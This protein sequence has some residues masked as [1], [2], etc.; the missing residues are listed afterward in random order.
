M[1]AHSPHIARKNRCLKHQMY[2]FHQGDATGWTPGCVLECELEAVVSTISNLTIPVPTQS[3]RALTTCRQ[4]PEI[5]PR[6]NLRRY[7]KLQCLPMNNLGHGHLNLPMTTSFHFYPNLK[8]FRRYLNRKISPVATGEA[9]ASLAGT[10][11][12]LLTNPTLTDV[13]ISIPQLPNGTSN[14]Q[15]TETRDTEL[16]NTNEPIAR[17]N[18]PST[19]GRGRSRAALSRCSTRATNFRSQNVSVR[20][21]RTP[22]RRGRPRGRPPQRAR[23]HTI[24]SRQTA[25][26][27]DTQPSITSDSDSDAPTAQL[28][29]DVD[30]GA[31]Q[32][33]PHY[34]LRR[35]RVP[36]YR[37][38]TCGFRDC[39]CVM[40]LNKS[41]T[42][43]IG[44]VKA[45]VDPKPQ[46][47]IHD[48]KLL[49][50]RVVIRAEKTYTGLERERIFP[51]DVVL[52]ELSKSKIAEEPCPRFKEWT[53]D[54]RGLEFTLAVTVPPVTPNIVFGPFNYERE[55]I[56]MV[57][58]I[59][60]DLLSDKYGITYQPAE[61]YRPAQYWWLL[62]TAPH[63]HSLVQPDIFQSCLESLRTLVT[64][65][66]ILCFHI[67]DLYRGKLRFR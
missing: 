8:L 40:A 33:N 14:L 37:C 54:L 64:E 27:T 60:A 16:S 12:P 56:Q 50:S 21:Q 26:E 39:T 51:V 66:L 59:T 62:V 47:F 23:G 19:R 28:T 61:V 34:G 2:R 45:P 36:R 49:V 53:S 55:P 52:E 41:P 43:P 46:P 24:S 57:R 15:N 5:I 32:V 25:R 38:G 22:S 18:V 6:L 10:S 9:G 13:S 3:V 58:C 31:T 17:N 44:P 65:E 20:A 1:T 7:S 29:S 67:V 35:N 4:M 48:G 11:A 42:I 63:A 30:Q